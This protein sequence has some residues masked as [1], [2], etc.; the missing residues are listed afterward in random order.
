MLPIR[1][2]LTILCL[3]LLSEIGNG[4]EIKVDHNELQQIYTQKELKGIILNPYNDVYLRFKTYGRKYIQSS[5]IVQ[6]RRISVR[7]YV[8]FNIFD[9]QFTPALSLRYRI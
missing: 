3:L 6:N 4:Q 1:S 8:Y 5:F 7:L 2:L 9:N